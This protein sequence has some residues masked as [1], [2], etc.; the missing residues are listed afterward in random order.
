[1]SRKIT[2]KD[3][4]NKIRELFEPDISEPRLPRLL[5]FLA[6]QPQSQPNMVAR[7]MPSNVQQEGVP[8]SPT[9][10]NLAGRQQLQELNTIAAKYPYLGAR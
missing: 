8:E 2:Q 4:S 9:M 7:G 10:P 5:E 1:M 6:T 3:I